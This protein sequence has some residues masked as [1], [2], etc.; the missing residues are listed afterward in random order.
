MDDAIDCVFLPSHDLGDLP[1]CQTRQ[2]ELR[3]GRAATIM[4]VQI[5]ARRPRQ[6]LRVAKRASK[7]VD[8]PRAP[9]GVREDNRRALWNMGED[10][11]QLVVERDDRFAPVSACPL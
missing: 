10:G 3:R 7:A 6:L 8:S 11:A 4:K 1:R 5:V 9:P 2:I